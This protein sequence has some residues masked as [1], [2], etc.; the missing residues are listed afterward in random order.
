LNA[1]TGAV[2]GTPTKAGAYSLR[3]KVTDSSTPAQTASATVT[4]IVNP[5]LVVTTSALPAGTV[6]QSYSANLSASG[7]VAPY[8]W[9]VTSGSLPF[10][11]TLDQ[12]TGAITGTPTG[13]ASGTVGVTVTDSS[14]PTAATTAKTFTLTVKAAKLAVATGSLPSGT[15]GQLYSAPV[16]ATGG[17]G[18]Y[19]WSA[20]GLPAGL[21]IN[22]STGAVSGTPTKTGTYTA[23]VKVTDASTPLQ[24]ASTS[25]G[26]VV[27][28]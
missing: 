24:A 7:G 11:L 21:T 12:S 5:Q 18:P 10:G 3:V 20:S 8:A 4:V 17:T 9:A 2:S 6:G 26:V 13:A 28:G 23:R 19:A 15:V 1:S 27:S 25:L 16:T 14:T 22:A